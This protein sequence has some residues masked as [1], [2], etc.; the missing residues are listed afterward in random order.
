MKVLTLFC[1]Q[2]M[3][4]KK[5]VGYKC[6]IAGVIFLLLAGIAALVA[7]AVIQKTLKSQEYGL[8]VNTHTIISTDHFGCIQNSCILYH[9]DINIRLFYF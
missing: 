4:P 9:S 8:E 6:R 5:K 3:A 1:Q 2:E 7:V